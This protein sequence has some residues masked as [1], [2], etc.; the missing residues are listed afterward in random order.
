M[1]TTEFRVS[2][3]E[4]QLF[5]DDF[6]VQAMDGL[7]RTMHTPAKKGAVLRADWTVEEDATP[8]IRSAP[9]YDVDAGLYKLWVRGRRE[10]KDGLHW[11]RVMP[12]ANT[13]HGEVVYDGGDPDPS[14][15]FKAFY[16]NRRHV[17]ADGVTWTQLP[18]DPVESQ[19]EHNFSFDRRDRLFVATV[20]QSGPHGRSVFLSTSEDFANW[21]KPELIFSTDEKD[22][23]LGRANIE[24]WLADPML[25]QPKNADPTV[26]NVDVYNMGVYRY[27]SM[28]IGH[29]AMYHA[30]APNANPT[31]P[32]TE[33]FH[34]VQLA[35]SRDLR[36]WQRLG[37]RKPFI[38]PS[39]LGTGAYDRQQIIGPSDVV[40]RGDELWIYYTGLKYRVTYEWIG[41]Y[42]DGEMRQL[43]GYEKDKGAICLA[44]LRRDGFISLDATADGGS[45]ETKA[46]KVP[47][48]ALHVNVD[49]HGGELV[50]E[51]LDGEGAVLATSVP[52]AGDMPNVR[53]EWR[54]GDSTMAGNDVS[55][56]FELRNAQLYSYWFE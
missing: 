17:S 27:E 50:V 54:N 3:G 14:R 46:F 15:R 53:V 1:D 34:L 7:E 45:V 9:Q 26:Y 21:T 37:D 4:R 48:G 35:C 47:S 56:F 20:K 2:T 40:V 44:V 42:P 52:I 36:N 16:P 31:Y 43:P 39:P 28:Y 6:G 13:D 11:Q 51:A 10:S 8:Q 55:L 49:A 5:L 32:N 29:P 38:G 25:Q 30:V 19:D 24:A 18:G 41:N 23:E 22:Q 33:G 12:D